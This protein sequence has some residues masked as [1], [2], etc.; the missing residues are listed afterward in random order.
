MT[1]FRCWYCEKQYAVADARRGERMVCAC[2]QRL[3]VPRRAWGNSRSRTPLE[4]LVEVTVYG[5]AGAVFGFVLGF[6]I[7]GRLP[8]FRRSFEILAAFT[9][10]GFVAGAVF[11]EP[12][13][14]WV[15]RQLR[16]RERT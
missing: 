14:D 7:A 8:F 3:K 5:G 9:A 2:G 10:V 13:I 11:G 4:W 12:G 6:L 16:E 15:G 1:G